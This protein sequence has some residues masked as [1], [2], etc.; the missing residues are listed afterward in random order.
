MDGIPTSTA[1]RATTGTDTTTPIVGQTVALFDKTVNKFR[2]K[3]IKTVTE[4][5]PNRSWDLEFDTSLSISEVFTPAVGALISPY[6]LSLQRLVPQ[7][8]AYVRT[9]GPGEMF[10]SLLDPG[11]RQR[12]WPFSP[13]EWP[14]VVTN[15][16]I[17]NASKASG[18]VSDT[19]VFL[20]DVPY[21]TAVGTP[22]VSVYLLQ[23][24]DF[25][26]FPQT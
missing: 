10:A 21:A 20:P 14:S 18:A 2:R 6:S 7:M 15:E 16:A 8:I 5:V 26:V 4:V 22:G 12:R 11:G 13:D 1:L 25:G 3:R 24:A 23:L 9:L 19:V 17:V